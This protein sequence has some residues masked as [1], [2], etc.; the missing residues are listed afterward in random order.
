MNNDTTQAGNTSANANDG[1]TIIDQDV[2]IQG[3]LRI[4]GQKSIVINGR[5]EGEIHSDGHV[6]VDTVGVINGSINAEDMVIAGRVD[7]DKDVNVVGRLTVCKGGV[8]IANRIIYGD[9]S[10]ESGAR[11]SGQ[12]EPRSQEGQ[13]SAGI[14]KFTGGHSAPKQRSALGQSV[15]A[16]M[17]AGTPSTPFES[18]RTL[19]FNESAKALVGADASD[20]EDLERA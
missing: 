14:S 19:P 16:V 8:L 5:V 13:E 7:T 17:G 1:T 4:S 10:H 11:M 12:L 2:E 18:I 3:V 9:L 6:R 20:L 15:A